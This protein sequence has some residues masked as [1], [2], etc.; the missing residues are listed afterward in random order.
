[1]TADF[2][3]LRVKMV[4]GQIRTTDV[5]SLPLLTA[6]LEVP[7]E[8]FVPDS[9]KPVAYIDEDILISE[10]G[11]RYLMKPSPFAKM[12]QLA[13]VGE[14][15]T[16]LVVGGG[17]GYAAAVLSRLA[18]SVVALESDAA[19]AADSAATISGLGYD[20]VS[21]VCAPLRGGHAQGEPYDVIF[22]AGSVD[23]LPETLT[24]QLAE[25]GRL[26]AAEGRGNAG[27]ARLYLK[28]NGVVTGRVA[29]NAAVKP[30]PGF[31]R[32][33]AFVF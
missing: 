7:R 22:V 32:A 21:V 16:V 8:A 19:L 14:Q 1:M 31:E 15:D 10:Q 9:R 33:A 17:T 13:E 27:V 25:G 23:E 18:K 24:D 30:L 3:D 2:S 4:D 6:M 12:A 28:S 20:N 5:T 11:G 26:V 29:F